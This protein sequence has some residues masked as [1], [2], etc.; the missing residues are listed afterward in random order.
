MKSVVTHNGTFHADDV[1]AVATI[2]LSHASDLVLT[3]TRDES[4]IE[5][6]DFV[7]DVG[8]IYNEESDCFDHHQS[9]F[10]LK[11][12]NGIPYASFGLTWKKY[13]LT[14]CGNEEIVREIDME[15]VQAIDAE[16]NGIRLGKKNKQNLYPF[17][18]A[19]V[20]NS[21]NPTWKEKDKN[22]DEIF[23]ECVTLA[24]T[25]L[26]RMITRARDK[27]EAQ[28]FVRLAYE[29][30]ADRR[31]I[32]LDN[33]YPARELLANY[34]EPLYIVRPGTKEGVWNV[35]TVRDDVHTF[36][37]R[38]DLPRKWG[39]KRDAELQRVTGVAD[40]IFC[41]KNLFYASAASRESAIAL[42]TMA[43]NA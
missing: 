21:F 13:G 1:F 15:L 19:S 12:D 35:E 22:Q 32:V 30:S 36:K 29:E 8:G 34:P 31:I 4:L 24:K 20:I 14:L 6:A 43:A 17:S 9:N 16:D 42:A 18:V 38:K 28:K 25:L 37:N 23:N 11:R 27:Y 33:Y 5:S 3:R 10:K 26:E 2:L 40:S 41:H 39:G 7:I